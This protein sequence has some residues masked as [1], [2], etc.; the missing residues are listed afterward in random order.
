M[1]FDRVV[2][3]KAQFS[4]DEQRGFALRDAILQVR[5]LAGVNGI[6]NYH[7]GSPYGVDTRAVILMRVVQGQWQVNR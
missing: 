4:E 5:E 7:A 6:Y 3:G 1:K 2:Q